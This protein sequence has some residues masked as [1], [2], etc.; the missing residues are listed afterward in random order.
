[1]EVQTFLIE[2]IKELIHDENALAEW[3]GLIEEMGV[4][5]Q[6][7]LSYKLDNSPIPFMS[8]NKNLENAIEMLCGR[9]VEYKEYDKEPIPIEVLKLLK[10]SENEKY[11]TKIVIR[12]DD[13]DPDPVA[14]GLTGYWYEPSYYNDS[15]KDIENIK[16]QTKNE[17][18]EAGANHP[19][20][21]EKAKYLIARWGAE[22]VSIND[23]IKLGRDKWVRKESVEQNKAIR[24]AQR[25]IE[26]IETNAFNTFGI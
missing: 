17:A 5:G 23:L 6:A 9:E 7:K 4:R 19:N 22:S 8:I 15:N 11:F 13:K 16:Y 25:A 1:M 24:D 12:W 20:F 14:I 2:E 3:Q 21:M 10:L 26:D 18:I